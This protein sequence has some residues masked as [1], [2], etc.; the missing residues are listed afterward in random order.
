[1]NLVDFVPQEQEVKVAIDLVQRLEVLSTKQLTTDIL[2][3]LLFSTHYIT[4]HKDFFH[5]ARNRHVTLIFT[6]KAQ[7][8]FNLGD[9]YMGL[10]ANLILYKLSSLE[11]KNQTEQ[12][13]ILTE[14]MVHHFW[15]SADEVYVKSIVC[16]MI[17]NVILNPE[18]PGYI[19]VG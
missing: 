5:K 17:P 3:S 19:I 1:M 8:S 13:I 18:L 10:N 16:E 7:L 4:Q 6:D 9:D 11:G 12:T 15:D 14:E 2:E